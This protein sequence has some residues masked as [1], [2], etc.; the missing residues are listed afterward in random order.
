MCTTC[1]SP[2]LQLV[3]GENEKTLGLKI[4]LHTI[5]MVKSSEQ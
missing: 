5:E 2:A 4:A 1:R 3:D